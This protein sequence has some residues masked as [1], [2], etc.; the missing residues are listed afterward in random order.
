MTAH[1]AGSRIVLRNMLRDKAGSYDLP[2]DAK[3]GLTSS[4]RT[5]PSK[6]FYDARG[7]H[8]FETITRLP[9][10][11]LTRAETEILE[12]ESGNIVEA[13]RPRV[14]VEFGSGAARKTRILLDAMLGRGLL[15][16][17]GPVDVSACLLYTSDAADDSSVV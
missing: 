17:Y 7:S 15:E 10:Y 2:A 5:L 11:Y 8:L 9:E 16:G 12:R 4:P 13:T 6:Y 1:A 14:L 3:A